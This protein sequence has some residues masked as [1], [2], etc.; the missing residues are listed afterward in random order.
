MIRK[1]RIIL[2]SIFSLVNFTIFLILLIRD[3]AHK[4]PFYLTLHSFWSNCFYFFICLILE[5]RAEWKNIY[6]EKILPFMQ[7]HYFKYSF[8]FTSFV[9]INY[10]LFAMLGSNFLKLPGDIVGY[11]FSTFLHG[12][13]F[14][15]VLTE[16]FISQHSFIPSYGKDILIIKCYFVLYFIISLI[17]MNSNIFAYEFMKITS[18]SQN[19]VVLLVSIIFLINFYMIYQWLAYKKNKNL[20]NDTI[21]I[22]RINSNQETNNSSINNSNDKEMHFVTQEIEDKK[23]KYSSNQKNQKDE[24]NNEK[25][26]RNILTNY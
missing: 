21:S 16:F 2:Y 18:T 14:I 19:F 1:S 22:R 26:K 3:N 5:I 25:I 13:E 10:Y 11:F 8:T 15:F 9:T 24:F 17:A 12:G 4:L 6:S 20:F 7:N 23:E